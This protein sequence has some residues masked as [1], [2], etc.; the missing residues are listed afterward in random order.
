MRRRSQG[1]PAEVAE[2]Q[3]NIGERFTQL[4]QTRRGETAVHDRTFET[5]TAQETDGRQAGRPQT[6]HDYPGTD[7]EAETDKTAGRIFVDE[8]VVHVHQRSFKVARPMSTKMTEMI[9][10]LTITRGSAILSIRN[11]GGSA[12][13]GRCAGRSI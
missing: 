5:V 1:A 9:Q 7:I 10:N 12:P 11:G 8:A 2:E 13:Y 6:Q 4:L 3:R